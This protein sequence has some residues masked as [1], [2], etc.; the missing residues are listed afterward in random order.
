[1]KSKHSLV[2]CGIVGGVIGSLLTASLVSPVTAQR[3]KFDAIQ[4]SGLTVVDDSGQTRIL[5]AAGEESGVS[6][7]FGKDMKIA[8]MF[9]EDEHG[10]IVNVFGKGKKSLLILAIDEHGGNIIVSDKDN[11]PVVHL[12]PKEHGGFVSVFGKGKGRAVM[13][14]DKYGN[15]VVGTRDQNGTENTLD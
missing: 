15:G 8:L 14:I 6:L 1:M 11:E 12:G 7:F 13:T 4:C 2:I 5:L 3:D 9:G 10:G